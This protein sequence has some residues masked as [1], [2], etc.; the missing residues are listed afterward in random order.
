MSNLEDYTAKLPVL[1]AI[2]KDQIVTPGSIPVDV[3][4]QEAE[5]LFNWVQKDQA[6]LTA[7]GLLWDIVT[8]LPIRCGALREA[9]SRWNSRRFTRKEAAQ[10]WADESPAAY[11]LRAEI[12]H[13]F[14]FAYRDDSRLLKKVSDIADGYG[15][16]DMLQDLNDLSRLGIE[17]PDPLTGI[18]FDVTLLDSA[19]AKA[20]TLASLYAVVT[21]D[22]AEYDEAKKVRDQAYTHVKET[23]DELYGFGQYV[24]WR[25]EDRLHGYSSNYLRRMRKKAASTPEEPAAEPPA[26]GDAPAQ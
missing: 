9:E 10:Q 6:A 8:D 5:N 26:A 14:R 21:G 23:V 20:D 22:R 18:N 24:F 17:N 1:Q 25:D 2:P 16:A 15:H 7:S 3:Y 4:I 19:A 12:L 13:A 11:D